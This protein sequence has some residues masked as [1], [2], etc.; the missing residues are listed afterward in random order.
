MSFQVGCVIATTVVGVAC[1]QSYTRRPSNLTSLNMRVQ[2]AQTRVLNR[3]HVGS[4]SIPRQPMSSITK[5][6]Q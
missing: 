6:H 4:L 1:F 2:H 5:R 3:E